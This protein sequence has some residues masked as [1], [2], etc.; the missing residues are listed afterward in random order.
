[1]TGPRV[2]A[3][4][5]GLLVTVSASVQLGRTPCSA[6]V[7][8]IVIAIIDGDTIRARD[9]D[10]QDLGRIRLLGID[11]PELAHGE[12]PQQCWAARAKARLAQLAPVGATIRLRPDPTQADRDD[13]YGRRLR[14]LLVDGR[15]IQEILLVEGQ[16]RPFWP[17]GP[18]TQA[19]TYR[20]SAQQ[21]ERNGRGL[22]AA[23]A[24]EG[25]SR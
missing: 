2:A 15:D 13:A 7:V 9:R 1:M 20:Q 8:G 10:G 24:T 6:E 19:T 21:A 18:G 11:A 17:E 22:W 12:S 5:V 16:A 23:C 3:A 14:Y 25:A 4:L